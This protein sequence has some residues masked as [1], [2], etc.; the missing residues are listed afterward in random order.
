M[1][2]KINGQF[3]EAQQ[4]MKMNTL[5]RRY[6]VFDFRKKIVPVIV[7]AFLVMTFSMYAEAKID[8]TL[9][10]EIVSLKLGMEGYTVGTTLTADQKK[11]ATANP[12]EGAYEGTYK[13]VDNGLNVVVAKDTDMVLA[14]YQQQQGADRKELKSMIGA[15]MDRFNEPT[16][17][18]HGKILYWA[19]NKHGAVTEE[20]FDEAK[21]IKQTAGLEIIATVKMN[22]ELDITPDLTEA[23]EDDKAKK[24][25]PAAG[26]IYFIITS[27]L[28]V[29]QFMDA[30]Q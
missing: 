26:D 22:S 12:V 17:I 18:A 7:A 11:T 30:R 14:M 9:L 4:T 28:L 20:I 24:E 3:R 10:T 16:T 23:K 5:R 6:G 2:I 21:K 27:D 25:Q 15:L 1:K 13:F 8:E 19:F 29:K